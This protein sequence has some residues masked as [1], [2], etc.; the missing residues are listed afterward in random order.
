MSQAN[1]DLFLA[2]AR[3]DLA[4]SDKLRAAKSH[5]ELLN[6]AT[7]HGHKLCKATVIRH[8]L[9]RLAGRSD[10]ELEELSE[11]L[12]ND[13]FGSVFLGKLI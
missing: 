8:H 2:E 12:Y 3:K 6:L 1:L 5:E 7:E 10:A 11:N 4:L 13:D 9:H